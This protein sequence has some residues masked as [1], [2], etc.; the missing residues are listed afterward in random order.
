MSR[1]A[2]NALVGILLLTGFA[3]SHNYVPGEIQKVPIVLK[4]GD[5]YTVSRGVLEKTD[6]L[7]DRGL[8]A[9][10]GK[11]LEPPSGAKVIDITGQRVYPGIIAPNSSLGLIEIGAVRGTDDRIEVGSIHPEVKAHTAYNP[12]SEILPTIRSNGIT[13]ALIVPRGGLISGQSSLI[14]LDGWTKEDAFVRESVGMHISWPSVSIA[15][16]LV[17]SKK[18]AERRKQIDRVR[19]G[20]YDAFEQARTY[21][22]A[23]SGE[24][25]IPVDS[26]SEAL[27]G[28]FAGKYRLFVQANDLRQIEQAIAFAEEF[29]LALVLVGGADSWK[30]APVLAQKSIPVILRRVQTLPMRADDPYDLTF[31][32]PELLRQAGV[33]FCLSYSSHSG[34]RNLPFEAGRAVA[35]GL[36]AE[37]ALRAITLSTAEILGVADELGSL[38][39]GKSAT[40]I[41]SEGDIL[42]HLTHRVTNMFIDGRAVDLNNKHR[43]LFDKYQQKPRPSAR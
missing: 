43:E 35:F 34:T 29:G 33:R 39:V 40:L 11:N 17:S 7:F 20:L 24:T 5:L 32:T 25:T 21:H 19:Q 15:A 13:T 30:M 31:R 22:A 36:P 6:I 2:T 8:I 42:D 38:E 9:E 37:E 12:D 14:H 27:S 3:R 18:L 10:I 1:L 26:R 41:V 16:A 28:L 23:R 4:N